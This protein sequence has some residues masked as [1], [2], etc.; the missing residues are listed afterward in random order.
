MVDEDVLDFSIPIFSATL[1]TDGETELDLKT[2]LSRE[3]LIRDILHN[4]S[5]EE[6]AVHFISNVFLE[7]LDE[8]IL[9]EDI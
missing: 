7:N 1:G 9:D 2:D 3:L 8:N 6:M 4:V 5:A